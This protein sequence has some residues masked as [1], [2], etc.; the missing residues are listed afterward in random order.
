MQAGT[1]AFN[2]WESDRDL[3]QDP[4]E[5]ITHAIAFRV[6][7][8]ASVPAPF[9]ATKKVADEN[10]AVW[11]EPE[12]TASVVVSRRSESRLNHRQVT[13]KGG[14]A[15][16]LQGRIIARGKAG[17]L[18][19]DLGGLEPGGK[20]RLAL[21]GLGCISARDAEDFT[22]KATASD[23]PEHVEELRLNGARGGFFTYEYTVPPD[24][25]LSVSFL[26]ENAN[27]ESSFM[28]FCAFL[29]ARIVE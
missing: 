18:S 16:L 3:P 24:G 12:H 23:A 19:L 10:W 28:I 21:F 29:N 14:G 7:P 5:T 22:V 8:D 17:G 4:P 20:Y 26:A 9:K 15:A 1:W 27:G 11:R 13:G 25:R 6:E 2:S